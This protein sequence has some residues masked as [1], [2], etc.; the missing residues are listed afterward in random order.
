MMEY[1]NLTST[2]NTNHVLFATSVDIEEI[3]W[4]NFWRNILFDC[5]V[6]IDTMKQLCLIRVF[7]FNEE[8]S[9]YVNK[10]LTI[11]GQ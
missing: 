2:V 6:D 4:R 10:L 1:N 8:V 5:S 11:L 9:Q 7:V 3:F